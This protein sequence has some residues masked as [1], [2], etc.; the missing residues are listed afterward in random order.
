MPRRPYRGSQQK[1]IIALD[2]G[3]TF[4][5][6]SYSILDPGIAPN[7]KGVTRFPEQENAGGDAKIP[8]I[9]YYDKSG[10]VRA[11]GAEALDESLV[12]TAEDEGWVKCS[13]FKLHMLPKWADTK[14]IS[15][16]I[17]PLPPGKDVVE[18]FGDFYAYLVKCTMAFI[19][20]SHQNGA[21]LL[22]SVKG[23]IEFILSHPNGWEGAQQQQLRKAAIYAGLIPDNDQGH[24]RIHFVTEGEASLHFCIEHGLSPYIK[25]GKGVMIVDAGGGTIDIS[26]YSGLPSSTTVDHPFEEIAAPTYKLKDSHYAQDVDLIAE[27]F[28][29]TTKHRFR[30]ATEPAYI[31]FGTMRDTDIK[32]DIRSGQLKLAGSDVASFFDPSVSSIVKEID[33]QR[34]KA[35]KPVS[36]VFLVGGFAASGYLFSKMRRHVEPAGLSF[37]RPD[38]GHANKAVA[39]GAISFYLDHTV[40]SRVAKYCYGLEVTRHFDPT[41]PEHQRR[42]NDTFEDDSGDI[43]LRDQFDTVLAKGVQVFEKEE[44]RRTYASNRKRLSDLHTINTSIYSY[45]GS[46]SDPTWMDTERDMY[47]VLCTVTADTREAAKALVPQL[48]PDGM[49]F[50]TLHFDIVIL[51]GRTEMKAQICWIENGKE[52]RGPARILYDT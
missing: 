17:A 19:Q 30:N 39:D 38:T 34:S 45:R 25:D 35:K 20:E 46:K 21:D 22:L 23:D 40:T 42:Q 12:A 31:K 29:K 4:S 15:E 33:N 44:F 43:R 2:L 13:R 24:E 1:L 5:G 32:L 51:F 16:A 26:T 11:A 48:R 6:V 3:T 28:D 41:N 10:K 7:I 47:P 8:T 37:S 18:V 49:P 27:C 9:M 36:S 52:K 50:S 14:E